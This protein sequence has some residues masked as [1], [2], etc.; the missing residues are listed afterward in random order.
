MG[1][2]RGFMM[3]QKA[4]DAPCPLHGVAQRSVGMGG[5]AIPCPW[6]HA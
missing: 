3:E 2:D 4:T 1:N 6:S 5:R